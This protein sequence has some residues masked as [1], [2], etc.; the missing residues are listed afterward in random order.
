MIFLFSSERLG[1]RGLVGTCCTCKTES[2]PGDLNMKFRSKSKFNH[3]FR[4][5]TVCTVLHKSFIRFQGKKSP[6]GKKCA[7][8]SSK[9]LK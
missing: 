2:V 8:F 7:F 9:C 5:Q 3:D 4:N 1:G 6:Q